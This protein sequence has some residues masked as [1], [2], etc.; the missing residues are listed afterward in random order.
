MNVRIQ[1]RGRTSKNTPKT[2]TYNQENDNKGH[3]TLIHWTAFIAALILIVATIRRGHAFEH[4]TR[5]TVDRCV[6]KSFALSLLGSALLNAHSIIGYTNRFNVQ[7]ILFY[8][9]I[10][11]WRIFH[12]CCHSQATR[13]MLLLAKEWRRVYVQQG[14][15]LCFSKDQKTTKYGTLF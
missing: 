12:L 6:F 10:C 9:R 2:N 4:V 11:Y 3:Y 1:V 5:S 15:P 7:M 13:L 8:D 14:Y